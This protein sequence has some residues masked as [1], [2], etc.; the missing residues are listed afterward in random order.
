MPTVTEP[1]KSDSARHFAVRNRL[2]RSLEATLYAQSRSAVS[3]MSRLNITYDSSYV[4]PPRTADP[5][6]RIP[7]STSAGASISSVSHTV[8][9][10]STTASHHSGRKRHLE[11]SVTDAPNDDERKAC[12]ELQREHLAQLDALST[13]RHKQ[14]SQPHRTVSASSS[15]DPAL[16]VPPEYAD[17]GRFFTHLEAIRQCCAA[18]E[19][20]DD[21]AVT[22][23]HPIRSAPL[24]FRERLWLH[25]A[26]TLQEYHYFLES[27]IS[28]GVP[29]SGFDS[30]SK[31]HA[32]HVPYKSYAVCEQCFMKIFDVSR[33]LWYQ[34]KKLVLAGDTPDAPFM[35]HRG[36]PPTTSSKDAE[37]RVLTHLPP[38]Q[39]VLTH[40][41]VRLV[42]QEASFA[43]NSGKAVMPQGTWKALYQRME[44]TT[45]VKASPRT[46][47][48]VIEPYRSEL[49]VSEREKFA[50]C[51]YCA[52][53][54][55]ERKKS[56]SAAELLEFQTALEAHWALARAH[57]E[58]YYH[59]NE[60]A[61]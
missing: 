34:R 38:V 9:T 32:L 26:C 59:S 52:T 47:R 13:K 29:A 40:G 19:K 55:N 8:T 41:L 10:A 17:L 12:F 22:L 48:R 56:S 37:R 39:E 42:A 6:P 43:T 46:F 5:P 15:T 11:G 18:P 27:S 44:Q 49:E 2:V 57:R 50:V 61:E 28:S 25:G 36:L 30:Q 3:T 23:D 7:P 54:E 53:K 1:N 20:L 60:K 35:G 14:S 16:S 4:I 31:H 24:L 58:A 33:G 51:K 45:G 21:V